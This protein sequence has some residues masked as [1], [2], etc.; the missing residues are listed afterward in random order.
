M[1]LKPVLGVTQLI[2]YGVGMIV[3][4]GIY[5]V[6]GAAAG[7]AGESLWLSFLLS[8]VV[9]LLTALSYAEMTTAFPTAGAEYVYLKRAF[10]KTDWV[11]FHV[12]FILLVGGAVTAATVATAFG[13]YM[14]VFVDLPASVSA[15]LLMVVCAAINIWGLRES[16][17][18]NILFTS[19]EVVGLVLVIA[20]G[21][22]HDGFVAPLTAAPQPGIIAGASILFFVYLGFEETANLAEEARNP[23]RDLPRAIF[24]SL[25][26]TTVLYVL[27]ALAVVALVSP[28]ELAQS[29]APLATAIETDWPRAGGVL[30]ALALFATGNTV[31]ITM[32][33]TSRLAYSLA[34]DDEIPGVFAQLL[35]RR[36]TPW[37]ATILILALAAAFVPLGS[38]RILA[39]LSSFS[40]LLAFLAV[41]LAVI[42]LRYRMPDQIRPFRVPFAIGRMPVVPIMGMGG[43]GVLL[44]HFEPTVYLAGLLAVPLSVAAYILR[45]GVRGR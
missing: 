7:A 24:I 8:A 26:I 39:E 31:L 25:A 19:V 32:I 44:A 41:N 34:R 5:S 6:I 14:R 20:A 29:G 28:K 21:L 43:I 9:A 23:G 45:P 15:A 11:A 30:A 36:R 38:I 35:T 1:T 10:P 22:T 33:A 18:V 12:G 37:M 3:G 4:A 17:W 42:V 2:F 16:S 13:S 27:V 40:A